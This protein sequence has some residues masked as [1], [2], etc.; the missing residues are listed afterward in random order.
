MSHIEPDDINF[1]D[2]EQAVGPLYACQCALKESV[3]DL[4]NSASHRRDALVIYDCLGSLEA[5]VD[6]LIELSPWASE[7]LLKEMKKYGEGLSTDSN[8]LLN[9]EDAIK[10]LTYQLEQYYS[11]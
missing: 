1:D 8:Y 7:F 9:F 3:N 5:T 11:H 10:S 2:Y 6:E 4:T